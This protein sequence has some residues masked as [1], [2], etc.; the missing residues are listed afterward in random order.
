MTVG[1]KVVLLVMQVVD[2]KEGQSVAQMAALMA[3]LMVEQKV[4]PLALDRE[5]MLFRLL[6][7]QRRSS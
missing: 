3:G 2:R 6:H 1:K 4:H 5:Y 7:P